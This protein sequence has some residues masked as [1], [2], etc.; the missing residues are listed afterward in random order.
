MK[1]SLLYINVYI[2]VPGKH[3]CVCVTFKAGGAR[4]SWE[5]ISRIYIYIYSCKQEAKGCGSRCSFTFL[6]KFR[7]SECYKLY[8]EN[9]KYIRVCL[10]TR[11]VGDWQFFFSGSVIIWYSRIIHNTAYT[12]R[13]TKPREQNIQWLILDVD[14]V[15]QCSHFH[16]DEDEC[17]TTPRPAWVVVYMESLPLTI[18]G[19]FKPRPSDRLFSLQVQS[20]W[21]TH[22]SWHSLELHPDTRMQKP[23]TKIAYSLINRSYISKW[24]RLRVK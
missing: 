7:P 1:P 20:L 13:I 14:N 23:T 21:Q 9:Y 17:Y 11:K 3:V 22:S 4:I 5:I 8:H 16:G 6:C 19:R 10:F 12:K 18:Q 15:F 24:W 2:R